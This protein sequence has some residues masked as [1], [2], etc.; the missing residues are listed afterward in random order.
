MS[1]TAQSIDLVSSARKAAA[2]AAARS[3]IQ[4]RP[5]DD[6]RPLQD[7]VAL[8]GSIWGPDERDLISVSVLRALAH[9]QNYVHGAYLEGEL[10]AAIM[11][12]FGWHQGMT[13]L[14]SHILGV[15]TAAQGRNVGF[16][17]KEHQRAWCLERGIST[18]TWT[19][20]PLVSRNAYFNLTKLGATVTDYY[21]SFY[22]EMN[23]SINGSDESDRVLIE[24]VLDSPR[25]IDASL[26]ALTPP[27]VDSL[28][29][30]GAEIAL[31][32][33]DDELPAERSSSAK[34]LLVGIPR[35]IVELRTA[36][37]ETARRWR[38]AAREVLKGALDDGYVI[39][40]MTRS[41]YYVLE[42]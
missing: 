34:T 18:I 35:D 4:I 7:A 12:F 3:G 22:G 37:P 26:G 29:S 28:V 14:H 17:V 40:A 36:Q 23:D 25:A 24:W 8:F 41:G 19:Y 2:D 38:L 16:A 39:A 30:S 9:S 20:D 11:G 27:D 1:T 15:S 31:E 32:V 33:A 5:L 42:S 21:P 10:V 13:Q 6:L